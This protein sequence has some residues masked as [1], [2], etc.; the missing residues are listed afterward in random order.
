MDLQTIHL[1]TKLPSRRLRYVLDHAMIPDLQIV[2][3]EN[4]GGQPR[5]FRDFDGFRI[6]CA[7]TLLEAGM[8]REPAAQ[9]VAAMACLPWGKGGPYLAQ[10]FKLEKP[11]SALLGDGQAMKVEF[12]SKPPRGWYRVDTL[13]QLDKFDPVVV[14]E[15]NIG[16]VRDTLLG[17]I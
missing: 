8:K 13:V 10:V 16:R 2:L 4:E 1:R 7:A 9:F 6:A 17:R 15:I 14:V 12:G 5:T 11:A 3:A